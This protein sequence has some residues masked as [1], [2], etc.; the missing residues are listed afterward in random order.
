M[1][2]AV[3]REFG[4][5]EELGIEEVEAPVPGPGEVLVRI[6][7]S[8][9]NPV[10]GLIRK[11]M[12]NPALPLPTII[13]SDVAGVVEQVGDGVTDVVAGDEVY[14]TSEL[15]T[16][17][18]AYAQYHVAAASI[19]APKPPSLSFEEAAAIPLAGGTAWEAI[20]RRLEVRPGQTVLVHGGSGG[21]GSFAVQ[22]AKAAGAAVL[23]TAGPDHQEL[24]RELGATPVDYQSEDFVEVARAHTDGLGVDAVL[25]TVGGAN[26]GGSSKATRDGGRI[27]TI[28][29]P[30]GR[31]DDLYQRNQT[32]YGIFLTRER[33]RLTEMTPIFERGLAEPKIA[34]TMPL[35]D[36]VNIHR[37]LDK[38]HN[39]GKLVIAVP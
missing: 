18:G 24:L 8:S 17:G 15:A 16:G 32:L 10:D 28:L 14:Y 25:D 34:A 19:V 5:P 39:A 11:G 35:D 3:L 4:D 38:S 29:A 30:D 6:R 27:A 1:R 33:R 2:A 26:I 12:A 37:R 36:I 13:G 23:S 7:A 9:A 20:V 21:V 22:F 31:L